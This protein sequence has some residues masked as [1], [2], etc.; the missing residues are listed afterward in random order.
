[1]N[2][3]GR[4]LWLAC[5]LAAVALV[6]LA[7]SGPPEVAASTPPPAGA[8]VDPDVSPD[9]VDPGAENPTADPGE[10]PA[11][12]GKPGSKAQAASERATARA[13]LARALSTDEAAE[14]ALVSVDALRRGD[15]G[16]S[17]MACVRGL[18]PGEGVASGEKFG[19]DMLTALDHVGVNGDL[20][21]MTGRFAGARWD[22]LSG[23]TA[24]PYGREARIF[25]EG[26]GEVV[27]VWRDQVVV[28]GRGVPAVQSALD[29]IEGRAAP[30]RAAPAFARGGGGE[31]RG[32]VAA[33]SLV[34][35]LSSFS[36]PGGGLRDALRAA[37]VLADY[38]VSVVNG[39]LQISV[40]LHAP[41]PAVK[42][43]E[44]AGPDDVPVEPADA[45]DAA[46]GVLKAGVAAL[47][48]PA[49]EVAASLPPFVGEILGGTRVQRTSDGLTLEM[50]VPASALQALF[51]QCR[52]MRAPV[53][54]LEE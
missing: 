10:T 24:R 14:Y 38:H 48:S 54:T 17:L 36:D 25:G 28:V 47:Q 29:R 16:P 11:P 30:G 43:A 2:V 3:L 45:L 44:P 37:G 32:V 8:L 6:G 9:E 5:A 33:A 40:A 53:A 50:D 34:E 23:A 52:A 20:A 31:L 12:A 4:M 26:E 1:M 18:V 27:G 21:A 13:A 51:D 7:L 49:P 42:P 22:T 35:P 46:E 15:L 19:V 41:D 39:G